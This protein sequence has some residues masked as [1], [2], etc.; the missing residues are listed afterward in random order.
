MMYKRIN[1]RYT[2]NFIQSSSLVMLLINRVSDI[3]NED[4][5]VEIGSG[6]GAI[7]FELSKNSKQVFTYELDPDIYKTLK[8]KIE[9][10]NIN[11]IVLKNEDF[12]KTDLN[13]LPKF[14]I[15]S[16]IPF[17]LSADIIRKLL[18]E[19]NKLL[20]GCIFLENEAAMRF[21]GQP[22]R[23]ESLLSLILKLNWKIKKLL[24]R[25]NVA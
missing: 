25:F 11:N 18:L 17:Y 1:I 19:N 7:T 22:Y 9:K 3:S 15:F 8:E 16:N 14:K 5:V 4:T 12:L 10:Q 21:I 13:V 23:K 2:Q 24:K 6:R 20:S